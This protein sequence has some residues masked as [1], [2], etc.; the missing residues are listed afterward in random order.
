MVPLRTWIAAARL[1]TLPLAFASIFLGTALAAS[2]DRFDLWVFLLCLITTLFYQI[3]SNYANDYGDGIKGTDAQREGE[4]RLVASGEISARQMRNAVVLFSLL[5]L[6]SG[7]FLSFYATRYLA[8]ELGYIFAGLGLLAIMA[9]IGY[10]VGPRAYGYAGFGDLAVLIFFG[11]VGVGGSF[12]LQTG[13]WQ[14][15]LLL[16]AS[17]L[18]FLAMGVL[19]LNNMRDRT[20]DQKAGKITLAVRLGAKGAKAY[21]L[22]L[23]VLAFDCSFLY[24]RLH[25]TG[26]GQ[27]L[28]FIA[29]VFWAFNAL[30]VY[31]AEKA[32]DYEPLLK[33]LALSTLLFALLFGLGKVL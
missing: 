8:P 25:P 1:R 21:H 11:W 29:A 22:L 30:K 10:T 19:N 13:Y 3:L 14:W 5:S 26:W 7:T 31:R 9:A 23:L 33:Q 17:A 6:V 18:G 27:N 16:P 4:K 12:F 20:E 24:N 15:S 2:Q 28:Y 32:S